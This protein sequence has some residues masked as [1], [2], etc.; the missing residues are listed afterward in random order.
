MTSA[1]HT[2]PQVLGLPRTK[3]LA[4]PGS[5][6]QGSLAG[7]RGGT[8]PAHRVCHC[9]AKTVTHGAQGRTFMGLCRLQGRHLSWT[10]PGL[11]HDW[12][13]LAGAFGSRAFPAIAHVPTQ[14]PHNLGVLLS[15]LWFALSYTLPMGLWPVCG[16]EVG[17]SG[18]RPSGVVKSVISTYQ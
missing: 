8:R 13:H 3:R 18:E 12:V 1:P 9:P 17:V 16:P 5:R 14:M 2:H 6:I 4:C 7:H 15:H 10:G 11:V